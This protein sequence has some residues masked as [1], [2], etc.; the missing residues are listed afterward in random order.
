LA[1]KN[2]HANVRQGSQKKSHSRA[3][4]QDE[5]DRDVQD[6]QDGQASSIS[7]RSKEEGGSEKEKGTKEGSGEQRYHSSVFVL[8]Y[9]FDMYTTDKHPTTNVNASDAVRVVA[10]VATAALATTEI[11]TATTRITKT[12]LRERFIKGAPCTFCRESPFPILSL[13]SGCVTARSVL[14]LKHAC[15][16]TFFICSYC[17]EACQRGIRHQK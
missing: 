5:K 15:I 8:Y 13:C 12:E 10:D 2:S 6:V 7:F 14:N 9:S 4:R 3:K 17:G 1:Q 11:A 16:Y